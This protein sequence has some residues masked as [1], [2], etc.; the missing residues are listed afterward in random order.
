[1]AEYG[2]QGGRRVDAYGNPIP[3]VYNA[4]GAGTGAHGTTGAGPYGTLHPQGGVVAAGGG[5]HGQLNPSL[6]VDAYGNPI[7]ESYNATGAATGAHGTT[8]AGPYGTA[9]PQGGGAAAA[10]GGHGQL[11]PSPPADAY[12]NPTPESYNS[13]GA[14]T[15]AHGRT[16][17]G[18]YGTA[19]QQ[20]GVPAPW[21]KPCP[22]VDA[23]GNPIRESYNATGTAT[24]A[25]GKTGVGPYGTAH[26]QGGVPAAGGGHGQLMPERERGHRRS[27]SSSSSSSSSVCDLYFNSQNKLIF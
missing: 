4:T 15:G 6:P 24:S 26:P 25:H 5:G 10:G 12:G 2:H 22:P 27:G 13:T 11:K 17:V 21:P 18:P 7:R 3:D 16:G 8:G 9:H 14:A 23:Y 20:G 19:H 1:M